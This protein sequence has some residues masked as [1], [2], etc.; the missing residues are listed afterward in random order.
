MTEPPGLA[1]SLAN[2]RIGLL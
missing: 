1:I 2:H